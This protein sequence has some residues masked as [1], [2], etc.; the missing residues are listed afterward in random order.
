MTAEELARAHA[1]FPVTAIQVKWLYSFFYFLFFFFFL[2]SFFF[3]VS[4]III[5]NIYIY[6]E[7]FFIII[8]FL[9]TSQRENLPVL[10][11]SQTGAKVDKHSTARQIDAVMLSNCG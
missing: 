7:F 3:R 1:V 9:S 6:L 8:I 11:G 5:I 2:F 4:F 10:I